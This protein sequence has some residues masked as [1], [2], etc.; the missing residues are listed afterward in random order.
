MS[1]IKVERLER[2]CVITI[3]RQERR[4]AIDQ[5]TAEALAAALEDFDARHDVVVGVLT[6][7]GGS[8]SAGMDLKALAAGGARPDTESRGML[9]ITGRPPVKPLIAAIEGPA[10]GGGFEI[11]LAC[12]L[13]VAATSASFGLP[14]VRRG[15]VAAA[16]GLIRL[17]RR[18]PAAVALELILTA[19]PITAERGYALGLV[20]QLCEPGQGRETALALAARIAANAPLAVRAAKRIAS[21]STNLSMADAFANQQPIVQMVRESED[22]REGTRAFVEKR[23]AEWQGR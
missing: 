12:D 16:G 3:D 2:V 19:E 14:E 23:A 22:A 7:A 13:I 21:D 4:N 6:G 10:L 1:G 20:N 9:G 5:P 11:A 15:L 8:F 18:I 17:P